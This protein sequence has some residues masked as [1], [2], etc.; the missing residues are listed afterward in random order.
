M[1]LCADP[2][3]VSQD[4]PLDCVSLGASFATCSFQRRCLC[5]FLKTGETFS[6]SRFP[7]AAHV[8]PM[9]SHTSSDL[10]EVGIAFHFHDHGLH[11]R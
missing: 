5:S 4:L 9:G 8:C 7:T 3:V 11:E 10:V 6:G 1:L 2:T